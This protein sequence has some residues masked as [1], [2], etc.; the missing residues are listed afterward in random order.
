MLVLACLAL[1]A[2]PNRTSAQQGPQIQ[3][4]GQVLN[5]SQQ[6]NMPHPRPGHY[7]Q[8]PP[9]ISNLSSFGEPAAIQRSP[10]PPDPY[11]QAA[12][13][14]NPYPL[15]PYHPVIYPDNSSLPTYDDTYTYPEPDPPA[16]G[17][18]EQNP[19]I[20]GSVESLFTFRKSRHVPTPL[21]TTSPSGPPPTVQPDAGVLG[22][23]TT[24]VLFGDKGLRDN[25]QHGLRGEIGV[26]IDP[27]ARLGVGA[28]FTNL[29]QDS[30]TFST[31]SDG[32]IGSRILAWP[33]FNTLTDQQASQ[34]IAYPEIVSGAV[35]VQSGIDI[36]GF[37]GFVRYQLGPYPITPNLFYLANG[38]MNKVH[39]IAHL[40]GIKRI[41]GLPAVAG[42]TYNLFS[43]P[44]MTKLDM[45]AGYQHNHVEDQL[46]IT[47]NLVSLDNSFLGQIGTT[48]DAFD[49]FETDN[50]FHGGTL[51][52]KSVSQHGRWSLTMLGKVALGQMHQNVTIN[53]QTVTTVP[54]GPT[55]VIDSGLLAQQS[56]IGSF[57]RDR[58]AV[59][60]EAQI[61]LSYN[62]LR[63]L[64]FGIGYDFMYWNDLALA[65]QQIDRN[66][67][68]TQT[69][70]DPSFNFINS[71]FFVHAA[72]LQLQLN[73]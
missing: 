16:S 12:Y 64:K 60:P 55:S 65:G 18:S 6:A 13:Q 39:W 8:G 25:P 14:Q 71:D 17:P 30:A 66:V 48:L 72:K 53:G 3:T 21:V 49:R 56:N 24:S 44:P 32:N 58:F 33:F 47:N 68:L 36:S 23:P 61:M 22:L 67:D 62:F 52:L 26:W 28:S 4:F 29:E 50:E 38:V 73:Y 43:S 15:R 27:G 40:P 20:W 51:G 63:S 19:R 41:P 59:I 34:L 10:A 69:N 31:S 35:Q 42:A 1:A 46:S 9:R 7:L 5:S 54:N 45:I 57:D 37:E 11:R 70:P 2:D